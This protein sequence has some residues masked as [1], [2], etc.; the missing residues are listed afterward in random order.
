MGSTVIYL[1]DV[2]LTVHGFYS[3]LVKRRS[4]ITGS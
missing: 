1:S 4:G 2:D 3:N